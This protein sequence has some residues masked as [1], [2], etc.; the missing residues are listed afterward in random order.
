MREVVI[1]AHAEAHLDAGHA[2]YERQAPGLGD[3]F[4][5][6]LWTDLDSLLL[7]AGTHSKQFGRFRMLSKRFPFAVYYDME[8]DLIRVFA[9]LDCRQN[10]SRTR[11]RLRR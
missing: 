6:A 11:R 7:Y 1:S 3:Y 4:L 10:P 5:D 9:I 2:F 8:G